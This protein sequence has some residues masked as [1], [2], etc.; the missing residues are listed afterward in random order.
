MD[1]EILPIIYGVVGLTTGYGLDDRGRSS[2]AGRVKN[3][4]QIVKAGS[5]VHPTS[6]QMGTRGSFPGDKAAGA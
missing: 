1:V 4:L 5:G 2:S 6:C 3:L